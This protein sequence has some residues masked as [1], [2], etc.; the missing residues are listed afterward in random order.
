[1]SG[2]PLPLPEPVTRNLPA[3]LLMV[4]S[5]ALFAL[6]DSFIKLAATQ[7]N[8]GQ[9]ILLQSIIAAL[10]F[11]TL[12]KLSG[13]PLLT[14]AFLAPPIVA[15]NIGEVLGVVCFVTALALMPLS[16]AS[17]ILQVQPLAVTL[18][19]ALFLRESVGWRRWTAV[20]IGFIG[21]LII[22][23]PGMA[24]FSPAALLA[25]AAVVG[26]AIRDLGTRRV[27]VDVSSLQLSTIASVIIIP[28]SLV[29][30]IVYGGWQPM[31]VTTILYVL[32][33]ATSGILA[34]YTITVALRIG[35]L[36]VI[37]PFRYAR[38]LFA[39]ILGAI[40]FGERPDLPMLIGSALIIGT[41][42]YAFYRER[43]HARQAA[44]ALNAEA[45]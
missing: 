1:M 18:G 24:G 2:T 25:V 32:G 42:I 19:A 30:M 6:D 40:L 14:R 10:V 7:I 8:V 36:S 21:V 31:S 39:L 33:A 34:Y 3:I 43:L 41:G 35:E 15:R 27:A 11:G 22:I 12:T 17:A 16:T 38:L 29:M 44:T 9:V 4:V 28:P 37:A 26:L 20:L 23:R 5:M 13:K 45:G